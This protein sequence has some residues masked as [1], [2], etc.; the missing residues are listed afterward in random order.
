[1]ADIFNI[2]LPADTQTPFSSPADFQQPNLIGPWSI[3][4]PP[5]PRNFKVE[6][7][8][9]AKTMVFTITD[10]YILRFAPIVG[11]KFWFLDIHI[12]GASLIAHPENA[13]AAFRQ[14][15]YITSVATSAQPGRTGQPLTSSITVKND[16]FYNK[17]G[18][19]FA[20]S[21][22]SQGQ[23]SFG[24]MPVRAPIGR[25]GDTTLQDDVTNQAA[26]LTPV[27]IFGRNVVKVDT[28]AKVPSVA[29]PGPPLHP[30][31]PP[32]FIPDE[33]PGHFAGYQIYLDN[34]QQ[35]GVGTLTEG[36]LISV[37]AVPA[38]SYMTGTFYLMPDSP[39]NHTV[40]L[41]FVTLGTAGQRTLPAT[42]SPSVTFANGI[43]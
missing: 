12:V 23:S 26:V 27:T 19:F 28:S 20:S 17:D 22:D 39:P 35:S 15:R 43:A 36:P 7:D 9:T 10:T 37:G 5:P 13:Q 8:D 4:T 16:Q 14:S 30:A 2:V 25:S 38:G 18:W 32:A 3:G 11:Y 31:P 21:I 34:Y 6:Q 41:Y 29:N 40:K 24:T 33:L 42:L 1:M